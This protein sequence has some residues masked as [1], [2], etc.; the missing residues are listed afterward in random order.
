MRIKYGTKY[1]CRSVRNIV[2]VT[3]YEKGH[4]YWCVFENGNGFFADKSDLEKL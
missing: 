4:G 3:R 2:E 1:F